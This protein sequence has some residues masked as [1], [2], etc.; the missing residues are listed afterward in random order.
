M[1]IPE[2]AHSALVI[3][4]ELS[5]EYRCRRVSASH[6]SQG[7]DISQYIIDTTST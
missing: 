3:K 1:V 4:R 2:I 6:I 5:N 7:N